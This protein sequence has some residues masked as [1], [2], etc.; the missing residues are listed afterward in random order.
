MSQSAGGL[1]YYADFRVGIAL[2][3]GIGRNGQGLRRV[4]ADIALADFGFESG[5]I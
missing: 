3:N 2:Q 4:R 1:A 5:Y